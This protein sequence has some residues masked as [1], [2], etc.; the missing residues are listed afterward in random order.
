[1]RP[2]VKA[3]L[4]GRHERPFSYL[5]P[6]RKTSMFAKQAKAIGAAVAAFVVA[7]VAAYLG[8]PVPPGIEELV[9]SAVA[10]GI[11]WAVVYFIPNAQQ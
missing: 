2:I 4:I 6:E 10:S 3:Y 8:F 5:Q 7:M 1:M 11:M 9:G